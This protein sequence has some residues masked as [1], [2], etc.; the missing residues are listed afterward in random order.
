[1]KYKLEFKWE[2]EIK[3]CIN[4]PMEIGFDGLEGEHYCH[5][6]HAKV[7]EYYTKERPPFCPLVEI[8]GSE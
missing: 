2:N 1:M 7:D 8:G 3:S 5:F 6:L 4:C